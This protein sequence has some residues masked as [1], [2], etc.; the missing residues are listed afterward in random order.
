MESV[1]RQVTELGTAASADLV[2][3]EEADPAAAIAHLRELL[4]TIS[5]L[6]GEA[7]R[8]TGLQ[9]TFK[10]SRGGSSRAHTCVVHRAMCMLA[11][12]QWH[13]PAV[14]LCWSHHTRTPAGHNP[15]GSGLPITSGS[16]SC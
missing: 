3:S 4:D 2:L 15:D 6:Q 1:Q 16:T 9:R 10:V 8:I 12:Q 11:C 7:D 14:R 5:A 13:L